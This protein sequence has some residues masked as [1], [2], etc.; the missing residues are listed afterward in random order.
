[1]QISQAPIA[2]EPAA[3]GGSRAPR[4]RKDRLAAELKALLGELSG[5]DLAGVNGSTTFVEMGFDSLF[6]TQASLAIEK[7][8]NTK[9]AFRQL[10][11]ELSTVEALA[12]QLDS[13]L[14]PGQSEARASEAAVCDRR[15]SRVDES[16][17]VADRR[18]RE[19]RVPLTDAQKE[20]WFA[21]QMS[22]GASCAYNETR[23]LHFR[24]PLRAKALL[25]ALQQLVDR[26]EA[27]RTTISPPGDEQLVHAR[28]K[29][30]VALI[31]LSTVDAAQREARLD[32][33]DAGEASRPFDLVNGP[34]VRAQ[35]VQLTT[36]HHVL[37]LTIHHV[38]CDG[39]SWG[40]LL[41]DLARLYSAEGGGANGEFAAPLQLSEFAREQ[42]CRD[43]SPE[44]AAAE[45]YWLKQFADG[46]PV[47]ELPTD[48]P[49]PSTW[50][51]NGARECSLIHPQLTGRLKQL[52]AQQNCTLFTTLLA[53]YYLLLHKLTH[54]ADIVVGIPTSDSAM[55]GGDTLIG[56]CI[57]FL[58]VCGRIADDLAFAKFLAAVKETFLEAHEHQHCTFGSLIQKLNPLRDPSRMPLVSVTFNVD[59]LRELPKFFGLDT[60]VTSSRNSF[61]NFDLSF[62]VT[63]IGDELRLGCRFHASLYSPQTIQRW[64]RHFETLLEEIV[65]A[66]ERCVGDLSLL[67]SDERKQILVEWN[68]TRAAYPRA[69]CVHQLFEEQVERTPETVAVEFNGQSLTYRELNDRANELARQLPAL[70]VGPDVPVGIAME[71]SPDMVT[72]VLAVLKAGG[73]YVPLDPAY[74]MERLQLM[75]ANARVPLVLTGGDFKLQ[76]SDCRL[77]RLGDVTA[78]APSTPGLQNPRSA[79]RGPQSSSLAYIIHTSGSTGVP[80]GV[81]IEHRS[82]VNFISWAQREFTRAEL[83]GV[84]FSTSL[85]FDLSVFELFVTLSSGGRVIIA[86]N[87][88]ELPK[89]PAKSEVTLINTVPSAIAELLRLNALPPSVRAVNLAG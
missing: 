22:D 64:L 42:A 52:S 9:V 1:M 67:S 10:M 11:Q 89:L 12:A 75:I 20:I 18:D 13:T 47:L 72:C 33:L 80:K 87:A 41:N 3:D 8:F 19:A 86:R 39:R 83:A 43:A 74:S 17:E 65:A 24:G 48:Q 5:R 16:P 14:P 44:R 69:K 73:A 6:F 27:L 84:L 59:R 15:H 61:T 37:L 60:E 25:T 85:C 7:R 30:D 46:A 31:D 28:L 71:R 4:T 2:V 45:A 81:A 35:L 49:R 57:N 55:V 23:L 51:F 66:P 21:S 79:I 62:N 50:T 40:V 34:L 38:V 82:V 54:Q 53:A 77:L 26:H 78:A 36:E 68:D 63:E 58:P 76:D 32:A 88:L 70:G 29:P 56:H